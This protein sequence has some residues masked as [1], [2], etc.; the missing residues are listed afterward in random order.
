MGVGKA[1]IVAGIGSRKGVSA[2]QVLAAVEAALEAHGLAVTALSALATTAFKR[3]EPAIFAAG[4]ELGLPVVVVGDETSSAASDRLSIPPHPASS[5]DKLGIGHPLPVGERRSDP[6]RQPP[7]PS[8][9]KNLAQPAKI[10]SPQRGEGGRAERRPDEGAATFEEG[11]ALGLPVVVAGYADPVP[12]PSIPP[13]KGEG[14]IHAPSCNPRE[15][16][17]QASNNLAAHTLTRSALSQSV[18][19]TPSVSETAALAVAGDGARLAGP[20]TIVGPVTCAI[21]FGGDDA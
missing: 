1:M 18:A 12:P 2:T 8:V 9:E 17:Q 6:P 4:R 7:T 16:V 3:D 13:H 14:G 19:G 11:E 10:S 15:H 21:A 20:R 5:L